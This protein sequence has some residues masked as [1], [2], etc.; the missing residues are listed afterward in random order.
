MDSP[1]ADYDSSVQCFC[2]AE[3]GC[4]QLEGSLSAIDLKARWEE[5]TLSPNT[6]VWREGWAQWHYLH[7]LVF[8]VFHHETFLKQINI[9]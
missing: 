6:S 4:V 3:Q 7:D 5:S 9:E 8:E 1:T 2:I